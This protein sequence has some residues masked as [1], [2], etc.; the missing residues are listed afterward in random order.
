MTTDYGILTQQITELESWSMGDALEAWRVWQGEDEDI[1][2]DEQW[3]AWHIFL[4]ALRR[5][6][7]NGDCRAIFEAVSV[8]SHY[9]LPLPKW[10]GESFEE[11]WRTVRE[12]KCR[13]LDE[14]FEFSA[15]GTNL[16]RARERRELS[17]AVAVSVAKY[18]S[19]MTIEEALDKAASEHGVSFSR[20]RE[21][22]Y[23]CFKEGWLFY[24]ANPYSPDFQRKAKSPGKPEE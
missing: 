3:K 4:P 13:S 2:P 5:R 10:C 19:D 14:A 22:Y 18:K 9:G 23:A 17:V 8:C 7:E 24:S 21:W 6:H 11:S 16:A 12:H 15:K 1:A 20:A